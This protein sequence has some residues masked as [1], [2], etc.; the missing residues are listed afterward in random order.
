MNSVMLRKT[1]A[2]EARV[3]V[4]ED[5]LLMFNVVCKMLLTAGISSQHCEWKPNGL[6]VTKFVQE[7]VNH[8]FDLVLMDIGLPHLD[9]Y[10]VLAELRTLTEFNDVPIIAVTGNVTPENMRRAKASGFNGFL[11]KPLDKNRFPAQIERILNGI[12]VWENT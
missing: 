2:E 5:N 4:F 6:S 9:G 8:G 1:Q 7:H 10:S 12:E 11:G 3:L